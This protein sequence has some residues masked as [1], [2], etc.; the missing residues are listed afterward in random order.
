MESTVLQIRPVQPISS[1]MPLYVDAQTWLLLILFTSLMQ[2][3]VLIIAGRITQRH[4]NGML[5]ANVL[6]N[7][8]RVAIYSPVIRAGGLRSWR[9]RAR[10]LTAETESYKIRIP[11]ARMSNAMTEQ[12]MANNALHHTE[13]RAITV[14][15]HARL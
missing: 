2:H 15:H 1:K 12:I 14:L 11:T 7:L 9:T 3:P 10:K 6:S 8:A 13:A 5:M 4:A